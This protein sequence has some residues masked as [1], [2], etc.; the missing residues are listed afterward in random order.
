[1]ETPSVNKAIK[2]EKQTENSKGVVSQ[3]KNRTLRKFRNEDEKEKETFPKIENKSVS[4]GSK[5]NSKIYE[6]DDFKVGVWGLPSEI[7][8]YYPKAQRIY[9]HFDKGGVNSVI[10]Y[11]SIP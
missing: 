3:L 8:N 5:R 11:H 9:F 10:S 6:T 4:R 2:N 1:M 7:S